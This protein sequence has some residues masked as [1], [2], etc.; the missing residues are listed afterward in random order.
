MLIVDCGSYVSVA[1]K[2]IMDKGIGVG[3][4]EGIAVAFATTVGNGVEIPLAV[5]NP[6]M[7]SMFTI[8]NFCFI[9]T[10]LKFERSYY[11]LLN[12]SI[13]RSSA[14]GMSCTKLSS[15]FSTTSN[16]SDAEEQ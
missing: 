6:P 12:T 8:F 4:I 2:V 14:G 16:R 10:S 3:V 1:V 15:D 11:F 7:K 9:A 13:V 5:N